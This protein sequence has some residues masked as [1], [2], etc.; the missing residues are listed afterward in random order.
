[1][2]REQLYIVI[3]C[4]NEANTIGDVVRSVRHLGS[5]L[6]VN[7]ASTDDSEPEA[8][9]AGAE[10]Y[11]H[12]E[13]RGYVGALESGFRE[14]VARGA[15]GI[16][17]F[18]ADG[19]HDPKNLETAIQHFRKGADVVVGIRPSRPRISERLFAWSFRCLYGVGDPL[20]GLKG[21]HRRVYEEAGYLDRAG[22]YGADLLRYA[23]RNKE[24]YR[25]ET[26][27]VEI[28]DREDL[29]R[30]GNALKANLRIFGSMLRLYTHP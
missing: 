28:H 1:M 9:A 23:C 2:Q 30:L 18:D 7:D 6:V 14:A 27:P 26:F 11:T 15:D 5:V 13:N 24:S 3:P 21:Y 17:T 10:I 12:A 16:F 19:Q 25:I 29:P 22:A 8:L 20:C 4:W